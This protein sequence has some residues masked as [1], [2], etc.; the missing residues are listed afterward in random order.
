MTDIRLGRQSG[1]ARTADI[2]RSAP[3]AA[4]K[5]ERQIEQLQDS[6]RVHQERS[7]DLQ[8]QVKLMERAVAGRT[9]L[10]AELAEVK[11]EVRELTRANREHV[12]R[13]EALQAEI[14]RLRKP[15]KKRTET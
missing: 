15:M 8:A 2:G 6:V 9:E 7:R 13:N 4:M 10:E 12:K 11:G 5:P 14:A 3:R 1:R